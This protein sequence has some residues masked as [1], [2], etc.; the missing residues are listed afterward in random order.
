MQNYSK[1]KVVLVKYPFTDLVNFKV[2]PAIIISK[3]VY[4]DIFIVPLTSKTLFL[5]ESEF[6]LNDWKKAGLNIVTAV[7]RGIYTI[8]SKLILKEIG[9]LT[10][11][12]FEKL[13]LSILHWLELK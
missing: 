9:Y 1:S 5:R 12:D 6:I 13:K 8:D 10:K 2:R 7:K 3:G 4:N 11:D